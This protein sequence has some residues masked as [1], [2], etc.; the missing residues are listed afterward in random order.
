MLR[1]PDINMVNM[2]IFR[3]L[4]DCSHTASK[5][6]LIWAIHT[7]QSAEGLRSLS[8]FHHY[9]TTSYVSRGLTDYAGTLCWGVLRSIP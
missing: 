3:I 7:N 2:N 1:I 4:A 6:I 5:C 8:L 9:L